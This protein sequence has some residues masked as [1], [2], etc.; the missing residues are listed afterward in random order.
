M[1]SGKRD[2][3][4][5]ADSD[6][7]SNIGNLSGVAAAAQSLY[8]AFPTGGNVIFADNMEAGVVAFDLQGGGSVTNVNTQQFSPARSLQIT[9][10]ASSGTGE[11]ITK[12]VTAF[13]TGKIGLE[14]KYRYNIGEVSIDVQYSIQLARAGTV[15]L[16]DGTPASFAPLWRVTVSADGGSVST[17][18]RSLKI[19][20]RVG[21]ANVTTTILN[22]IEIPHPDHACWNTAKLVVDPETGEYQ[23]FLINDIEIDLTGHYCAQAG[24]LNNYNGQFWTLTIQAVTQ[25][26]AAKNIFVD[27]VVITRDEP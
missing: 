12:K 14:A 16:A 24:L 3:G 21:G 26:A 4:V 27:D 17:G 11:S 9:T 7:G 10:S 15:L 2:F 1:A 20:E 6:P 8:P 5:S 13:V 22:P 18:V 23:K 25:S 19:Y